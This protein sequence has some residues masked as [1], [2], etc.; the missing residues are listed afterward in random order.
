MSYDISEHVAAQRNV[1]SSDRS[2]FSTVR[3]TVT[4][5]RNC[6]GTVSIILRDVRGGM[7]RDTRLAVTTITLTPGSLESTDPVMALRAALMAVTG[8]GLAE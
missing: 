5:N 8:R 2:Q 4:R 7:L 6:T 3:L 1:R